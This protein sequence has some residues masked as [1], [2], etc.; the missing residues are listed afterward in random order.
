MKN[1]NIFAREKL[2]SSR[3]KNEKN[4]REKKNGGREK[5]EKWAKKW[6]WK[7]KSAREKN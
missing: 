3:E 5:F 2:F 7:T 4:T 6:A 1:I